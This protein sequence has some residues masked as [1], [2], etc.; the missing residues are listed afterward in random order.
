MRSES[1]AYRQDELGDLARQIAS[2]IKTETP[3]QRNPNIV[4]PSFA[5]TPAPRPEQVAA[6]N[7]IVKAA[8]LIGARQE[9]IA[10]SERR[11]QEAEELVQTLRRTLQET[12]DNLR[13]AL[14]VGQRERRRAEDLER[15]SAE[16]MDRNQAVVAEAGAR[17]DV[18]EKRADLA[19]DYL[20]TLQTLIRERLEA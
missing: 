13:A 8:D 2:Q 16:L 18:A 20:A 17:L 10:I 6:L 7:A 9:Q 4:R 11:A 5:R 1:V 19:E 12:E 15:R 14:E 3:A